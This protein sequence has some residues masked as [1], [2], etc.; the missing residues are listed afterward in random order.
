M[1]FGYDIFLSFSSEDIL[2]ARSVYQQ[3]TKHKLKV[4]WSDDTLKN[5]LGSSW[6]DKIEESVESSQHMVILITKNSLESVW[7]LREYKAFLH[8]CYIENKRRLIPLLYKDVS[9]NDMPLFMREFQTFNMSKP[10]A[11]KDLGDLI[12]SSSPRLTTTG[13]FEHQTIHI[14][15]DEG[16]N[17]TNEK[18]AIESMEIDS[19]NSENEKIEHHFETFNDPRDNNIYKTIKIGQ[20]TWFAEN[21]N[22]DSGKS[23]IYK[24]NLELNKIYGRLYTW[25]DAMESCP[26]GWRIPNHID[27]DKLVHHLG[28]YEISGG[29]LKLSEDANL[30][31]KGGAFLNESG[32]SA[33]YGG[34]ALNNSFVGLKRKTYFWSSDE[35][36]IDNAWWYAMYKISDQIFR[37]YQEKLVYVSVRCIQDS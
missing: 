33:I 16:P 6:F 32:F 5:E 12:C 10:E 36:N 24:N 18:H 29:K 20:Q 14:N 25:D 35:Y 23:I 11:V 13:N 26:K 15:T 3:L 1:E 7:V 2:I 27:W 8:S 19:N 37:Q 17:P 31:T 28:G 4:F 21:L 22:Y 30:E 9:I 34:M